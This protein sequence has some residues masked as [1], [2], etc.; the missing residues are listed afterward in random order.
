MLKICLKRRE[1]L[2]F[3]R[4]RRPSSNTG[5][6]CLQKKLSYGAVESSLHTKLRR[7]PKDNYL[8]SFSTGWEVW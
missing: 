2:E 7:C 1:N 3:K 6:S 4:Q 5:L 8:E